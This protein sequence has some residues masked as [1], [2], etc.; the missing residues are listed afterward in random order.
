MTIDDYAEWAATVAKVRAA[1]GT[2]KLA[3]LGLGLSE[4]FASACR[5]YISSFVILT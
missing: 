2:E 4:K 3:Y 5:H 1:A